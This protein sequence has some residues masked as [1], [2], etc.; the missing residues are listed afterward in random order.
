MG[1]TAGPPADITQLQEAIRVENGHIV[2]VLETSVTDT[3]G[4]F[5][6]TLENPSSNTRTLVANVIRP[7]ATQTGTVR[8]YDQFTSSGE[9]SGGTSV[10]IDNLILDSAG[11]TDSG[12]M[13]ARRND[14]FTSAGTHSIEVIGGGVGGNAIGA[15]GTVGEFLLEPDRAVVIE[16]TNNSNNTARAT[17]TIV[18]HET[19]DIYSD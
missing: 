18:Y 9:P 8:V 11:A 7:S 2:S 1:F 14:T 16:Y 13:N 17:I 19:D 4:T 6:L 12:T 5:S 3:G 10:T 15:S